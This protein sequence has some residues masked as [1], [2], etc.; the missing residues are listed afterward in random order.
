MAEPQDA[1]VPMLIKIQQDI[2]AGRK[3][4]KALQAKVNDIAETALEIRED[5]A[6]T[7]RDMLMHLGMA[8]LEARS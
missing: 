5:I 4:T 2:S 8:A 1:V 3:D 6:D 7:R